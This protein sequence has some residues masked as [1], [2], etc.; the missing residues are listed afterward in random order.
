MKLFCLPPLILAGCVSPVLPP[1]V[2]ADYPLGY[3]VFASSENNRCSFGVQD[4]MG[5]SNSQLSE[6]MQELPVKSRLVDV[7]DV[8]ASEGCVV[9]AFRLVKK[10]GFSAI[11]VRNRQGLDYPS[12]LPPM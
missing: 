2:S 7:V 1:Y 10:A 6:W 9:E 3:P 5:L 8:S 4:M 12:G 11:S